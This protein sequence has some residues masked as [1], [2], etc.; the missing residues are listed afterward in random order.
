MDG[1]EILEVRYGR[2][3]RRGKLTVHIVNNPADSRIAKLS[4][5]SEVT[6]PRPTRAGSWSRLISSERL[7][8]RRQRVFRYR[9]I[10]KSRF[11]LVGTR[12]ALPGRRPSA[13]HHFIAVPTGDADKAIRPNGQ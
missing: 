7:R 2:E 11:M 4:S 10:S 1:T 8:W 9:T 13:I 3:E 5:C 12:A 6:V